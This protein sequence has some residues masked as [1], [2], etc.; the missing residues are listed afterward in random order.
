MLFKSV[1]RAVEKLT[2]GGILQ[3]N[4]MFRRKDKS[5]PNCESMTTGRSQTS[6]SK[7]GAILP[8][9]ARTAYKKGI[10][11]T[12]ESTT[13]E[14]SGINMLTSPRN[15][16]SESK[17]SVASVAQLPATETKSPFLQQQSA[18]KNDAHLTS[19]DGTSSRS[20]HHAKTVKKSHFDSD[21]NPSLITSKRCKIM[22]NLQTGSSQTRKT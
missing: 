4:N 9:E 22:P 19:V 13:Y 11:L 8:I 7:Q 14:P 1:H 3:L 15:A 17:R 5:D 21:Y 18:I 6:N 10:Q 20:T 2:A 12:E 16:P